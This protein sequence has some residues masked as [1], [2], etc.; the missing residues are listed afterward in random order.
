M[1][2]GYVVVGVQVDGQSAGLAVALPTF[3]TNVRP[4]TS[5]RSDVAGQLY[6]LGEHGFTI[7]THIHLPFRVFLL[8]VICERRRH[9]EAHV[10]VFTV[11]WFLSCVQ[12]HVVLQR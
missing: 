6:G 9:A 12:S 3:P 11:V 2:L 10:A 4:I 7:L 1:R 8:G 5:V